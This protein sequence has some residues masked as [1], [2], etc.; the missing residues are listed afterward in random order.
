MERPE[1]HRLA[2]Y[3]LNEAAQYYEL[4]EP[5]LGSAFLEEVDRTRGDESQASTQLL[6]RPRLTRTPETVPVA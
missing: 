2:E 3:E 5:G 1:F 4:E 6:G